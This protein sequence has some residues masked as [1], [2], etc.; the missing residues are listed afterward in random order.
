MKYCHIRSHSVQLA[1]L[2]SSG[3]G[4]E[5]SPA[6]EPRN[7]FKTFAARLC[8]PVSCA[9]SRHPSTQPCLPKGRT[10]RPFCLSPPAGVPLRARWQVQRVRALV[11]IIPR[12]P[13]VAVMP[14]APGLSTCEERAS[15]SARLH[16]R[17]PLAWR[18]RP[19]W[20]VY[21]ATSERS[22]LDSA[23][24][25]LCL[26]IPACICVFPRVR[27]SDHSFL[28]NLFIW[29]ACLGVFRL[30]LLACRH[31]VPPNLL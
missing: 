7:P 21:R 5:R 16:Y 12:A 31:F 10:G 26:A 23:T 22:G 9:R 18:R 24:L 29:S 25:E 2:S 20:L 4:L 15:C 13:P 8:D 11:W 17:P 30:Q 19:T 3:R 28:F 6:A 27:T 14:T 1:F